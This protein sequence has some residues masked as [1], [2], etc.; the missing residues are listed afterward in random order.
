MPD[1]EDTHNIAAIRKLLMAAFTV[2]DLHRFCHDRPLFRPI[3]DR[4]APDQGLDDLVDETITYCEKWFLLDQ[5]LDEVQRHNP[6]QYDRYGPYR[7]EARQEAHPPRT[8]PTSLPV[9][10][11]PRRLPGWIW[12]AAS[13]ALVIIILGIALAWLRDRGQPGQATRLITESAIVLVSATPGL[14][15]TPSPTPTCTP[16]PTHTS[17]TPAATDTPTT[18]P[19]P[20]PPP[21]PLTTSISMELF[22]E[23]CTEGKFESPPPS[24]GFFSPLTS[25]EL[26]ERPEAIK[27]SWDVSRSGAYAGCNIDLH[28]EFASGVQDSTY[29][30]LWVQGQEGGEQF[31]LGLRS[32]DGK[33]RKVRVEALAEGRQITIL[34]AE[35]A[36][37]NGVDLAHLDQ[38]TIAFEYALGA[39]SRRGSMCIGEI[40]FGW[41]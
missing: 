30:V 13:A 33:E 1:N 5:L 34:L 17:A 36:N 27:V 41:P 32:T 9:T 26:S 11:P 38:L 21:I 31:R 18:T 22:K 25:C 8:L 20:T 23:I 7:Y 24:E 19:T 29:L 15:A 16:S 39:G 6:A 2:K 3:V 4:F 35:F 10:P 12:P 14:S 40:G 37:D 28:P